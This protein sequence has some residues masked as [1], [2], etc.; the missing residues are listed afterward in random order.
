MSANLY[1]RR[2]PQKPEGKPL[3]DALKFIFRDK[4]GCDGNWC[5]LGLGRDYIAGLAAAGV[6]GAA[7]LLEQWDDA[8]GELQ[9]RL[10]Y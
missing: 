4:L 3:P 7:D 10:E 8:D 5:S 9:F 6:E 2:R 1:V